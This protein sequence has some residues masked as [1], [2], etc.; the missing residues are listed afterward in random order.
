MT[1]RFVRV[2][3]AVLIGVASLQAAAAALPR[4]ALA[5]S[6]PPLSFAAAVSGS[7]LIVEGTVTEVLLDGLAYRLEVTEV[8]KGGPLG[9]VVRIGP[10]ADDDAGRGCEV[11]LSVG[12]HVILG[13]VDAD[14]TLN[15]LATAVW[16]VAPDGSLSSPGELWQVAADADRLREMLRAAV[17]DTAMAPNAPASPLGLV[18]AGLLAAAAV[19]AFS[20]RRRKPRSASECRKRQSAV[21]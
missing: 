11:G 8:F 6:G 2:W 3:L 9:A 7:E 12:D 10:A 19:A 15:S 21:H 17:P 4:P 18:G 20:A 16:F 14:V 1:A 5:C 13:V